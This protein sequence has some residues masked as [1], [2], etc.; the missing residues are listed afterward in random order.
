MFFCEA[1]YPG[2]EKE[3]PHRHGMAILRSKVFVF[4]SPGLY[5]SSLCY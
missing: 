2:D 5:F 4:G 1:K 3:F